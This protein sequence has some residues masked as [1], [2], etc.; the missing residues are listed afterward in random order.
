MIYDYVMNNTRQ[1]IYQGGGL[2]RWRCHFPGHEDGITSDK[3]SC[4]GYPAGKEKYGRCWCFGCNRSA[5]VVDL[6][7]Q[8]R[9]GIFVTPGKMTDP[10]TRKAYREAFDALD[11]GGYVTNDLSFESTPET[12]R[13]FTEIERKFLTKVAERMSHD[14]RRDDHAIAYLKQRGVEPAAWV[15]VA[16]RNQMGHILTIARQMGDEG[17]PV[18]CGIATARYPN[19]MHY[20][21]KDSVVVFQR[22]FGVSYYQA[23]SLGE[24]RYYNPVGIAK[25]P[26]AVVS[27]PDA[28][29]FAAEGFFK[30]AW[31]IPFGWNVFAPLGSA[32]DRIPTPQLSKIDKGMYIGDRNV[33]GQQATARL[34]ERASLSG[35][36]IAC[37]TTPRGYVD[38]DLWA[39]GIG[40][41]N[42]HDEMQQ[43]LRRI[44]R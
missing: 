23:R 29:W 41:R 37:L 5:S 27:S 9:Y 26:L 40:Y 33:P 7:V 13:S 21:L 3:W 14:L 2:A 6:Y 43:T 8:T 28:P 19:F 16:R 42:A 12:G 22:D 25:R 38:P 18:R 36:S 4:V 30:V 44:I 34:H 32:A 17:L 20:L 31:A 10:A 39:K 24:K 1:I 35:L 11:R 15:G